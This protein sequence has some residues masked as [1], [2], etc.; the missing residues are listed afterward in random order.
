MDEYG[1]KIP[2]SDKPHTQI[3][4]KVSDNGYSYTQAREWNYD[5]KGNL[6]PTR[7]IDFTDHRRA[8]VHPN[9]HQHRW[10]EN[11]TGGTLKRD[12]KAESL[13]ISNYMSDNTALS[14]NPKNKF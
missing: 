8:D 3:S 10:E 12:K 1:N 13:D 6:V 7:D 5:A 2:D 14:E 4:T 9:P 11:S